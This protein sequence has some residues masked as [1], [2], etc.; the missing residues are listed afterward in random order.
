MRSRAAA[1]AAA[2]PTRAAQFRADFCRVE[3]SFGFSRR[4]HQHKSTSVGLLDGDTVQSLQKFPLK[5]RDDAFG[6][7]CTGERGEFRAHT[8][9][10]SEPIGPPV[11]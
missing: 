4:F 6:T 1:A 2:G 10:L 9:F 5:P 11:S 3:R 8:F 7:S